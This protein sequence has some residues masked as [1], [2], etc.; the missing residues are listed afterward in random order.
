MGNLGFHYS[1]KVVF[2]LGSH[3]EPK[4]L[5]VRNP[6]RNCREM[7]MEKHRWRESEVPG[8]ELLFNAS[9]QPSLQGM[10][11]SHLGSTS[12]SSEFS[13]PKLTLSGPEM[14]LPP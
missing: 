5:E 9:G 12:S 14:N 2:L 7:H 3:C 6:M 8:P 4:G 11:V 13:S 10:R 1:G